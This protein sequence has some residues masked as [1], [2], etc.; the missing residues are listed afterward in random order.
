MFI[1]HW[2]LSVLL[3]Y[4]SIYNTYEMMRYESYAKIGIRTSVSIIILVDLS[5]KTTWLMS[6]KRCKFTTYDNI[7]LKCCVLVVWVALR[8]NVAQV[9]HGHSS[10]PKWCTIIALTTL[11]RLGD[12][13]YHSND[14]LRLDKKKCSDDSLL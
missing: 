9:I 1:Q 12:T 11:C 4:V 5:M 6:L 14:D 3:E 2:F 13:L 10:K 8:L 7:A